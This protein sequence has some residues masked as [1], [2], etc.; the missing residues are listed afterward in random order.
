[1]RLLA[2]GENHRDMAA[3]RHLSEQT[4]KNLLSDIYRK[5]GVRSRAEAVAVALQQ[6]VIRL[7]G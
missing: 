3:K 5:P 6:G 4:I 1:L 2:E 7:A